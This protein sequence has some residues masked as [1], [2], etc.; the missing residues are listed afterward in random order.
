MEADGMSD[1]RKTTHQ[2]HDKG[3]RALLQSRKAFMQLLRYFVGADWVNLIDEQALILVDKDAGTKR[4][5]GFRLPPIVP[6]VL[7][8]GK[9]KWTAQRSFRNY[10][11]KSVVFGD[12][13]VD[14]QYHLIDIKRWDPAALLKM[15]GILPLA[16]GI[17]GMNG[18]EELQR[19]LQKSVEVINQLAPEEIGLLD[20][21]L[22]RVLA[23]LLE[24][25]NTGVHPSLSIKPGEGSNMVSNLE[26]AIKREMAAYKKEA[27][28]EG[29]LEGKLEGKQ[30]SARTIALRLLQ[31]GMTSKEVADLTDL[32]PEEVMELM[33]KPN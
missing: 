30:E 1:A 10:Q 21:Y 17:D 14:F 28:R 7:Y 26:R 22:K 33:S 8:N 31:K 20:T 3:F 16:I 24:K 4:R 6:V 29:K 32:P 15:E 9:Y 18:L 12:C 2:P 23:L 27:I 19:R 11:A 13:L 25:G 5:I